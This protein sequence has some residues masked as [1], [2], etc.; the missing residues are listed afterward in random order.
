[1]NKTSSEDLECTTAEM[2]ET[3]H[4]TNSVYIAAPGTNHLFEKKHQ[5]LRQTECFIV[6][7]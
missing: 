1:M 5:A 2:F 3:I 7:H 6:S 4:R